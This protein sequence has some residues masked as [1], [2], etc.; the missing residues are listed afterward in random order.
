[1]LPVVTSNVVFATNATPKPTASQ[2]SAGRRASATVAAPTSAES[3]PDRP[4]YDPMSVSAI[5]ASAI[6]GAPTA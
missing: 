3:S 2:R 4:R 6:T 1:M 5:A